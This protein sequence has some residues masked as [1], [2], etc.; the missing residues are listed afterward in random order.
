MSHIIG[1]TIYHLEVIC[2]YSASLYEQTVSLD[3]T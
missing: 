2:V 3:E 1:K